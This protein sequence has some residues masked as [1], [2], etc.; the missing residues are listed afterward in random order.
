MEMLIVPA[1]IAIGLKIA[2]LIRYGES[3]VS[4]N[5]NLALFFGAALMLN[6][7]E[8][9]G[10]EGEYQG[11]TM[12]TI[13]L[14]YYCSAVFLV[15]AFLNLALEFSKFNYRLTFIKATLN[16]LLALL[17]V[18][19]V[20]NR[21][22]IADAQFTAITFTRV[23]GPAYFL[24]QIY[25]T[26]GMLFGVMLLLYGFRKANESFSRQRCLVLLLSTLP[27][28]GL[29][30]LVILT[31]AAGS[32]LTAALFMPV[33]LT[34]M[35]AVIVYAEEKTRLFKLLT[36]VPYSRERKLHQQ[37]V[38]KLTDCI[39]IS[40]HPDTTSEALNLKQ[41]MREFEGHVVEHTVGYY[42]GNQKMAAQALGVSEAT[43]SRRAR[44]LQL[45]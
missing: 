22:L 23:E 39:A 20:F 28:I 4:N 5:N 21:S 43:I 6:L 18:N 26:V 16:T 30:F 27:P 44:A 35:L 2:I 8:V 34:I 45:N 37:V 24:L 10:F 36:L 9:F 40:S 33:A 41:M 31:M 32:T 19:I 3:L 7:T 25:L 14:T 11:N 17:V 29:S 42:G 13:L 38:N 1:L 12:L 15:H